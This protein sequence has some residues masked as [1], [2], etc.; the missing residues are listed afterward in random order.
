MN[1]SIAVAAAVTIAALGITP[2]LAD[3]V[4]VTG[5]IS[6][7]EVA[8]TAQCGAIDVTMV[9]NRTRPHDVIEGTTF[10]LDKVSG[11]DLA[12]QA[13]WDEVKGMDVDKVRDAHKDGS[14]H[15]TT[16]ATGHAYFTGLPIG[17]YYVSATVPNDGNHLKPQEFIITLPTG[18]NEG[19]NCTPIINAKFEPVPSTTTPSTTTPDYPPFDPKNPDTSTPGTP[20]PTT[21]PTDEVGG[22][23]NAP[24]GG[25]D[26]RQDQVL[27]ISRA[28]AT[29]GAAVIGVF[30]A[31][32][33]LMVI[34]IFLVRRRK[35]ER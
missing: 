6:G 30:A 4:T 24:N 22:I 19:W 35:N 27:G 33:A 9:V 31:A 10:T 17:A 16:D 32:V 14:W 15:A 7:L 21:T 8:E 34:G 5:S 1:R 25:G 29:T 2:A 18:S 26:P 11:I 28:L 13:G 3:V 20:P 12:T 23:H